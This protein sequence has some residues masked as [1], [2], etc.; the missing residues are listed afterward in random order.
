ML[1]RTPLV[2]CLTGLALVCRPAAL[3]RADEARPPEDA[4][5]AEGLR[6]FNDQ[7]HAV[8]ISKCVKCHGGQKTESGFS[9]VDRDALV[10]GGDLGLDVVPGKAKESPLLAFLRHEEEPHMPKDAAKL[11]DEEIAA[12]AAWIDAGAPYSKA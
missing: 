7:V 2:L 1:R 3:A 6:L 11:S 10:K 4:T 5:S 8:L 9:V 12:L